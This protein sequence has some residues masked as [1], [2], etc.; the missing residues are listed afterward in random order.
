MEIQLETETESTQ[1][2]TWRR[3]WSEFKHALGGRNQESLEMQLESE[4]ERTQRYTPWP[5]SSEFGDA[6][7]ACYDRARL[8]EYLDVVDL[9]AGD[10]R[11]SRC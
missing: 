9:E 4:I 7:V 8:E 5:S 11:R 3:C 1:R 2:C 10:G 6:L